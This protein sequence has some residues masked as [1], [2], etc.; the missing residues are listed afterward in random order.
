MI[1][2][3]NSDRAVSMCDSS[4]VDAAQSAVESPNNLYNKADEPTA[5]YNYITN[6]YTYAFMSSKHCI[7]IGNCLYFQGEITPFGKLLTATSSRL[8][9][10]VSPTEYNIVYR[11]IPNKKGVP[12]GTPTEK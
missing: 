9:C 4:R 5:V 8:I 1:R 2:L 6:D 7:S 10:E 12:L 11:P 3:F